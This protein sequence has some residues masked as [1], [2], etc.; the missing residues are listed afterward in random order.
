MAFIKCNE[1]GHKVC[2]RFWAWP[3][4]TFNSRHTMTPC[5]FHDIKNVVLEIRSKNA[6]MPEILPPY[7]AKE[8]KRAGFS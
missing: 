2:A 6:A 4:T 8:T 7:G 5:A 1:C 3:R